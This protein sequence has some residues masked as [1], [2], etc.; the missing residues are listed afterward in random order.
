M[1]EGIPKPGTTA[2]R[3][4]SRSPALQEVKISPPPGCRNPGRGT[5]TYKAVC[6][7]TATDLLS[8]VPFIKLACDIRVPR[9][10]R[11]ERRLEV[12]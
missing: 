1:H 8:P 9:E 2:G 5:W 12:R 7:A 11:S 6:G 4:V 3:G 10:K